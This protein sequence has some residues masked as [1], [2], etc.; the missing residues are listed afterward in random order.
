MKDRFRQ[1]TTAQLAAMPTT[2]LTADA[3]VRI[4]VSAGFKCHYKASVHEALVD[5]YDCDGAFIGGLD[6]VSILGGE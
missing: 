3:A 5:L 4:G 6:R 2:R 1:R